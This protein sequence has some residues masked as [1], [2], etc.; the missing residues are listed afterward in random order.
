MTS[1]VASAPGK[2]VL[3]GEYAVL[4]GAP[5]VSMALDRRAVVRIDAREPAGLRTLGAVRGSDS[6]LL[7]ATLATLGVDRPD[8]FIELDTGAF[9]DPGAGIKLGIGSS[10][11]LAAALVVALSGCESTIGERLR[12]ALEAH[13]RLQGNRGSGVDVATSVCGGLVRYRR[14]RM[15]ERIDWPPGLAF[16]ILSSGVAANTREQLAR[17][18]ADADF[19]A[20][21]EAATRTASAWTDANTGTIIG[22]MR[23]WVDALAAFDVEYGLGVFAA[24]HGELARRASGDGLVYKPCGAGGGDIGIVLGADSGAVERFVAFAR[25]TGFARLEAALDDRGAS[26][27][28]DPQ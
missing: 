2:L 13:R 9:V 1:V 11:A 6:R 16:A 20:L 23:R 12:Y 4:A 18:P 22:A 24:G 25:G 7:D 10:G 27:E 26:T 5:A 19:G 17:L 8:A 3:A 14:D 21:G 15:P 28:G